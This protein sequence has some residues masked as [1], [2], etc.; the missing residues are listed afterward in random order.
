[1]IA[2]EVMSGFGRTGKWFGVDHWNVIP[3]LITLAKGLTS[4]YAPLGA[5]AMRDDIADFFKDRVYQGGLTYNSHPISMAAA[6]AN[7]QV[8]QED[9]LVARAE[10][11]GKLLRSLLNNLGETH[12]SVGEVRSIG[13]FG[14][15]ELVRNR[16]TRE[17]MAPFGGTST[18]M[19]GIRQYLLTH[20][21]YAYIHWNVILLVPP[22]II[23][24][25]Q[26]EEGFGVLDEALRI[27]DEAV[28]G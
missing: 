26:L 23:S 13:L 12:P 28:Q 5:V 22:L 24:S 21:V 7:I 18:E 10:Q 19:T 20:G 2:D 14:A 27:A 17:P 15:I 25:A 8:L 3:D 4:G 16:G 1:L 9:H 11:Q 6:I